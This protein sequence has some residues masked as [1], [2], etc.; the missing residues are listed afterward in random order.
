MK[1][2]RSLIRV[3][4][5][6]IITGILFLNHSVTYGE[7]PGS[8]VFDP[9]TR[10]YFVAGNTKFLIK[11]AAES[12]LVDRIEVSVNG[13]EYKLYEGAIKFEREGKHTLKFRAIS[14]VNNWAPVQ[15]TEVFVDLTPP[16][17]KA[18]F[19][20]QRY[21]KN[22]DTLYAAVNSSITLQA[23]DNLSG[24]SSIEVSYDGNSYMTYTAPIGIEKLGAKLFG[25]V[26][27]IA[28]A[29]PKSRFPWSSLL[30]VRRRSPN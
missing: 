21:F 28:W 14:P 3:S 24:V 26:Q 8:M 20:D 30:T 18:I 22:D 9:A 25:S 16:S 6:L 1:K 5:L 19:S 7:Q 13:G 4:F 29:T 10:K 17:T 2:D 11:Q 27:K 23:Q 15:F 12:S